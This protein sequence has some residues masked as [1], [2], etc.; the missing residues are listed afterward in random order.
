MDFSNDFAVPQP[1]D[2]V[3]AS[4]TNLE[5]ILPLVPYTTVL[6]GSGSSVTAQ[7]KIR[8]G[9]V[10]MTYVGTAEIIERDDI[11]HRAVMSATARQSGGRS[12][13]NA[14]VEIQLTPAGGQTTGR[15][16]SMVNVPALGPQTGVATI[17]RTTQGMIDTF[18]QNLAA[19][20]T[21]LLAA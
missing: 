19:M 14:R 2:Q 6:Q 12:C 1:I 4:M 18:A 21:P 11:N 16:M 9:A 17:Q 10:S 13:V 8:F 20:Q 7:I 15:L 3:W 5:R